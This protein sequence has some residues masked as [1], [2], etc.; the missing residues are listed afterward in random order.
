M[1]APSLQAKDNAMAR[2]Y[3]AT[4]AQ[5]PDN[6]AAIKKAQVAWL[7]DAMRVLAPQSE[8]RI[9]LVVRMIRG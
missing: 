6:V 4:L 1:C 3:A 9:A 7:G 2:Q 5:N 8:W